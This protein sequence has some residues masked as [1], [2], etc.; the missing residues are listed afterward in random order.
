M[1]EPS[2][3]S[4]SGSTRYPSFVRGQDVIICVIGP[5]G[6]EG[7][8]GYF[9]RKRGDIERCGAT[10]WY[11]GSAALDVES[12]RQYG[13]S[14]TEQGVTPYCYF[15]LPASKGGAKDTKSTV[16]A[17]HYRPSSEDEWIEL[18]TEMSSVGGRMS[19]RACAMV[20]DELEEFEE[21]TLKL[22][23][24]DYSMP[25]LEEP[26]TEHAPSYDPVS[27]G[28]GRSTLLISFCAENYWA[29]APTS[30]RKPGSRTRQRGVVAR[31]RLAPPYAVYISR[32][33]GDA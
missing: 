23:L 9:P 18:P 33:G 10:Y 4:E 14:S 3:S 28:I 30:K 6:G 22:D 24:W 19:K 17:T 2:G 1:N 5:H 25:L 12:I 32:Q 29:T 7:R 26:G 8:D 31:G 21:G 15:I 16:S 11:M 13:V 20:F 27:I